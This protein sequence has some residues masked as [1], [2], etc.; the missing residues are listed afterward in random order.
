[1]V[2]LTIKTVLSHEGIGEDNTD[3]SIDYGDYLL[4]YKKIS[5]KE[6]DKKQQEAQ[7]LLKG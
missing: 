4:K 3:L 6:Y 1:M 2:F 7:D 5:K